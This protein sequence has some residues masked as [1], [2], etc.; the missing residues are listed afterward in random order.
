MAVLKA[1][2]PTWHSQVSIKAYLDPQEVHSVEKEVR[3]DRIELN[4]P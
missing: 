2:L 1:W 4:Q 3:S